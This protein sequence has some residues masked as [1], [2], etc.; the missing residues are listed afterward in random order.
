MANTLLLDFQKAL[1]GF[2]D[3]LSQQFPR[4]PDFI[5]IRIMIK[6]RLP[7][8]EVMN[9]FINIILPQKELIKSRSDTFWTEKNSLFS[10]GDFKT[11]TFKNLWKSKLDDE[12]KKII[13]SWLDSFISMVEKYQK[14]K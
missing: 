13:W 12:D 8:L 10:L 5:L 2:F 3:E 1:V 4:E 7:V 9:F 14:I 6:D 11:D